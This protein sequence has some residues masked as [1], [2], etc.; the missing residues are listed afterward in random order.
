[1]KKYRVYVRRYNT[2]PIWSGICWPRCSIGG[3]RHNI[4]NCVEVLIDKSGF[5]KNHGA[6]Q[7]ICMG[8]GRRHG[9]KHFDDK[10]W[11]YLLDDVNW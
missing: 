10:A 7:L 9:I 3:K 11:V 5:L 1:M 2:I 6:A 8:C 4:W